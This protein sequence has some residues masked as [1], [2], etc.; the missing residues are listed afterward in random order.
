MFTVIFIFFR[1]RT[2]VRQLKQKLGFNANSKYWQHN[3]SCRIPNFTNAQEQN[4]CFAQIILLFKLEA[5]EVDS[6]KANMRQFH[7]IEDDVV[8]HLFVKQLLTDF[9]IHSHLSVFA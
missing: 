1:F 2:N 3:A 4:N 7:E 6:Y 8:K 9:F 5:V